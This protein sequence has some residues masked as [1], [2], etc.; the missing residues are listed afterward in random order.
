M[1]RALPDLAKRSI[2][3]SFNDIF[4]SGDMPESWRVTKIVPIPKQG[5]DLN[6]I[7]NFRPISLLSV[8]LKLLNMMIKQRLIIYQVDV[9]H[10]GVTAQLLPVSMSFFIE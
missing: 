9:L 4:I 5:K 10:T 1:I 7:S 3:T 6:V 2:L 8:F